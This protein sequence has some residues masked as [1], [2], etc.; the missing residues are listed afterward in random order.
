[1]TKFF[2]LFSSRTFWTLVLIVVWN[3]FIV[4][5]SHVPEDVSTLINL[6]LVAFASYFKINPSQLYTIPPT[7]PA[8]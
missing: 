2:Q 4:Y 7:T 5:G 8:S 3:T 1:M 6:I